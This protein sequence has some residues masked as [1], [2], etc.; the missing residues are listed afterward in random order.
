MMKLVQKS[1]GSGTVQYQP[2]VII[3]APRSGT[4]MLRDV[5]CQLDR[6]GTW[7]CDEIN[8]IWRHGNISHSSDEISTKLL[9]S[10]TKEYIRKKFDQRA[11]R[12]GLKFLIEKTCANSLRVP[13]VQEVFPNAKYIFIY[14][15]G[16]DAVASAKIRWGAKMEFK[17]LVKKARFVPFIDLP[18]YA[19]KYMLNRAHRLFSREK[20]LA[21]W[22]PKLE[23][24]EELLESYSLEEVCAYQWKK[25]VTAA[26]Q[27]LN[28]KTDK[29]VI[30]V[31]YESF[32]ANPEEQL[33][34]IADWLG[35]V[36]TSSVIS[37]AVS[38]VSER[39]VGKGHKQLGGDVMRKVNPIIEGTLSKYGYAK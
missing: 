25:C 20:R 30:R 37:N 38:D 5:L 9:S 18:Y 29:Q 10:S 16:L 11:K 23:N 12:D 6:V 39:S 33:I 19:I 4:N 31:C 32:V 1:R 36:Y 26:D 17:Y 13:F 2:V 14:R 22:G 34:A 15:N 27:A 7:P 28:E 3:G 24:M 21:F 8:Y 35:A